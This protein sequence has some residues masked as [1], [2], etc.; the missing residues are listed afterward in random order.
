MTTTKPLPQ[1]I[2]AEKIPL[3]RLLCDVAPNRTRSATSPADLADRP[4]TLVLESG[5]T[6]EN[7]RTFSAAFRSLALLSLLA[8][9]S[10][11]A[12]RLGKRLYILQQI[13]LAIR[14]VFWLV[15]DQ[16]EGGPYPLEYMVTVNASLP[17]L[18]TE[19]GHARKF[20]EGH[21]GHLLDMMQ[22]HP[23]T[24]TT[25][26]EREMRLLGTLKELFSGRLPDSKGY[27][28]RGHHEKVTS[29]QMQFDTDPDT[30]LLDDPALISRLMSDNSLLQDCSDFQ[31]QTDDPQTTKTVATS[32]TSSSV[33]DG[34]STDAEEVQAWRS[35]TKEAVFNPWH[36]ADSSTQTT[37]PDDLESF[38]ARAQTQLTTKKPVTSPQSMR[39]VCAMLRHQGE[40][41][42]RASHLSRFDSSTLGGR[43]VEAVFSFILKTSQVDSSGQT[44]CTQDKKQIA[45]ASLFALM[46]TSGLPIERLARIRFTLSDHSKTSN[47]PG[48]SVNLFDRNTL[49]ADHVLLELSQAMLSFTIA[50]LPHHRAKLD[51]S[52]EDAE[53]HQTNTG[54]S[55]RDS[56]QTGDGD[57]PVAGHGNKTVETAIESTSIISIKLP[58]F[59]CDVLKLHIQ[60][61]RISRE[62]IRKDAHI[63]NR[64]K[65]LPDL[66][67][68]SHVKGIK[69]V[70]DDLNA[71]EA[72]DLTATKVERW[73]SNRMQ[74]MAGPADAPSAQL[75]TGA[76]SPDGHCAAFYQLCHADRLSAIHTQTFAEL[77]AEGYWP[78][79]L[80]T[81]TLHVPSESKA[82]TWYGTVTVPSLQMI[83]LHVTDA[84]SKLRQWVDPDTANGFKAIPSKLTKGGISNGLEALQA[85][86]N[87]LVSY[88]MVWLEVGLGA[89]PTYRRWESNLQFDL[90]A[91]RLCISVKDDQQF[92]HFAYLPLTTAFIEVYLQLLEVRHLV[93]QVL[94]RL[95]NP[96]EQEDLLQLLSVIT[97]DAF[98]RPVRNAQNWRHSLT[99]NGT[100]NFWLCEDGQVV[101]PTLSTLYETLDANAI[102]RN[103]GRKFFRTLG[104]HPENMEAE[105]GNGDTVTFQSP[106]ITDAAMRLIQGHSRDGEHVFAI[107]SAANLHSVLESALPRIEELE[108]YTGLEAISFNPINVL[109]YWTR[110]LHRKAARKRIVHPT[111]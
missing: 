65:N 96:D 35:L 7:P 77:Q 86:H 91:R 16:S 88:I 4:N 13:D 76:V 63:Q 109:K 56:D 84:K 108:T 80:Q 40:A 60:A 107:T 106:A 5:E 101:A 3:L 78:E 97:A 89:R 43:D 49:R 68:P 21:Y 27:V 94:E 41:V 51:G 57:E 18:F 2:S 47:S 55:R 62:G 81:P 53:L 104:R 105:L 14:S 22:K 20:F 10:F 98:T 1:T 42:K 95:K 52:A 103:A 44:A 79:H 38:Y 74:T 85:I 9:G 70:I 59:A 15:D 75:L 33:T 58:D 92:T 83:R 110:L 30:S 31:I 72:V 24:F 37:D 8:L 17:E 73:V 23:E 50:V 90:Q 64:W 6:V 54:E 26:K 28:S 71:S 45:V 99:P 67:T 34:A 32:S 82:K 46:V 25:V 87:A 39:V 19:I 36:D 61:N 100:G 11:E 69:S 111:L 66:F 12:G 93:A 102:A 48:N 29:D